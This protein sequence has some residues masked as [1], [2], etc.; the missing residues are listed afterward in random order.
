[1]AYT[2]L[3]HV[4]NE[5]PILAEMD[6]LPDPNSSYIVCTNPRRRDGKSLHY[7]TP[8]AVSF[9]FPWNRI[10]FIE[11]MPTE[12]ERKEIVEWFRE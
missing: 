11:I 10:T 5:D 3:I 6:D 2:V 4:S 12:E 7:I 9:I 8:E 1:M